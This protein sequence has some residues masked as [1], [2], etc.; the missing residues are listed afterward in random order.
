MS[1][2]VD[3]PGLAAT[4]NCFTANRMSEV[5]DTTSMPV[6]LHGISCKQHYLLR[7]VLLRLAAKAEPLLLGTCARPCRIRT[8]A[9]CKRAR[10]VCSKPAQKTLL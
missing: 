5:F 7:R 2:L 3:L 4:L 1:C 6:V 9:A 10:H 8:Q